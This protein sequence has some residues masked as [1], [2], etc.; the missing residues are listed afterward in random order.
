MKQTILIIAAILAIMSCGTN[1]QQSSENNETSASVPAFSADSA[2]GYIA[3]QCSYGPRVM[4]SAAHDSCAQY[5]IGQFAS[6]GLCVST[7]TGEAKLYDGTPISLCN[8]IASTPDTAD[9][10]PRIII[11]SHWDSRPWADNDADEGNHHTPIDGANDGASGVGVMMEIARLIQNDTLGVGIDFICFD[12]EDC[13]TPEWDDTGMPDPDT[14]CIGSQYWAANVETAMPYYNNCRYGILLDMVGGN[15]C[16]FKK[17]AYSK[18]YAPNVVDKVWATA[19]RAGF[20]N[21][22]KNEEG[23]AVTDDHLQVNKAGIRCI[24][25]IA[26]DIHNESSFPSTWHTINDN[27]QNINRQTLKAVGQTLVEIIYNE[28]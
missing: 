2:Y 24:D 3:G 28:K 11:C 4:N 1:R 6:F 5:I 25:I 21:Y 12:A 20:G 18:Y 23:G 7:Q 8:I 19:Q 16:M 13:G 27:I 9:A 10:K 26:S 14:W 17:E 22:F 15:D